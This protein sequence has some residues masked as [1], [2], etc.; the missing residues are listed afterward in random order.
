[1]G[2]HSVHKLIEKAGSDCQ[3]LVVRRDSMKSAALHPM[4]GNSP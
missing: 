3:E 2:F 1:V 4:K